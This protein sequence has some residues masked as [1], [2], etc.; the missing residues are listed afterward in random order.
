MKP[1][2]EIFS[3]ITLFWC[4][5]SFAQPDVIFYSIEEAATVHPDSVYRLDLSKEKLTEI[6]ETI[7]I[8]KNLREL[9]LSQNKLTSLPD[10][11]LL[12]N[13][14][15]LYLEKNDL[16]TFSNS[17][18]LNTSLTHLYMG[19]NNIKYLPES[20]GNLQNL[21][22]F[23][24]WFNPIQDLPMALTTMKKLRFMDLRGITYSKDFQKKWN[25]LLPWVKI[26][27]DLGCDCAN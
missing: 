1:I 3:V 14:E 15:V 4:I 8:F 19:K 11:F 22:V 24:I 20:I 13:L 2:A 9:N 12:P 21:V 27:F 26:E 7:Y 6:P 17:I 5:N 16:D 10:N 25:A 18:C 23:D